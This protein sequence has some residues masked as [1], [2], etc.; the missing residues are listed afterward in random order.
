VAKALRLRWPGLVA[1]EPECRIVIGH[2][3]FFVG[4]P[5]AIIVDPIAD[6]DSACRELT[7]QFTD[8]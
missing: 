8:F 3:W 7:G 1:L 2:V 4:A 5:I 6:F